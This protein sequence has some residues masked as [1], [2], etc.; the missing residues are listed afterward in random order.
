VPAWKKPEEKEEEKPKKRK[1]EEGV[2]KALI[3]VP[4]TVTA[5]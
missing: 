2:E 4:V 1:L 3:S 5:T